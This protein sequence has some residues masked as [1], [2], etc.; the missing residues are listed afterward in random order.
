MARTSGWDVNIPKAPKKSDTAAIDYNKLIAV[1]ERKLER[2]RQAFL[3]EIDTI[4][5]YAQNKKE[6]AERIESLVAK[7]DKETPVVIDID[8]Y[9]K[10][11]ADIVDFI[12]RTDVT[13][14]AKNE[15]LRTIIDKIIFE[16][17]KGNLAIYFHAF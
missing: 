9:A 5:Q 10:K 14:A 3:A 16:K 7:R 1:E 17:A 12:K 15:A 2:A 4:E 13:A 6:I 8:A 11:V